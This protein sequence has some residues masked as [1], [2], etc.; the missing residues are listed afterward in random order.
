MHSTVVKRVF[1]MFMSCLRG[2]AESEMLH[3]IMQAIDML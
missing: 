2:Y 1:R 3:G